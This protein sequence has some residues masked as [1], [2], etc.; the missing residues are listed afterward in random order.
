MIGVV[1]ENPKLHAAIFTF[2]LLIITSFIVLPMATESNF[3]HVLPDLLRGTL[4]ETI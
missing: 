1:F 4:L 2:V 3:C